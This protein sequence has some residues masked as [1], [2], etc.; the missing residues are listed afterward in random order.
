MTSTA[1]LGSSRSQRP[2]HFGPGTA[3][4][5]WDLT[6]IAPI[7]RAVPVQVGLSTVDTSVEDNSY[8][9]P[10]RMPVREPVRRPNIRVQARFDSLQRWEGR[11]AEVTKSSF[12]AI[13]VDLAAAI[14]EEVEFGL[15]EVSRDDL[16][17]VEPGAV[18]YWSIGYRTEPSG[19]RSRCSVLVFRRLP[20]WSSRDI[21]LAVQRAKSL[22]NRL[23]W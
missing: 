4:I 1:N 22:K 20:A 9:T 5:D 14:E 8:L 7:P 16:D 18:F 21:T 2:D 19:E 23:G 10:R 12:T 17:L 15:D 13:T 11:V 6:P 3:P